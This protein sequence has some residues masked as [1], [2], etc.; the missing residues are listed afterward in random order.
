MLV[1]KIYLFLM[2]LDD[3]IIL[4]TFSRHLYDLNSCMVIYFEFVYLVN[5]SLM[6][7]ILT[8]SSLWSPYLWP[9]WSR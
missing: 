2:N 5:G 8:P 6:E 4:F 3:L 1:V 9:V 7:F